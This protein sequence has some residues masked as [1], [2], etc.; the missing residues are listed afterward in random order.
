LNGKILVAAVLSVSTASAATVGVLYTRVVSPRHVEARGASGEAPTVAVT[1]AVVLSAQEGFFEG[2]AESGDAPVCPS[3]T[4]QTGCVMISPASS[5]RLDILGYTVTIPPVWLGGDSED[6]LAQQSPVPWLE[7]GDPFSESWGVGG[8][9]REVAPAPDGGNSATNSGFEIQS[10]S[11]DRFA[12]TSANVWAA[13]R[14]RDWLFSPYAFRQIAF[15][16][17]LSQPNVSRLPIGPSTLTVPLVP[18]G[19]RFGGDAPEPSTWLMT[20]AGLT[21]LGVFKRRRSGSAL[22]PAARYVA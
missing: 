18:V 22:R 14:G 6:V 3:Q 10:L 13:F 7:D 12:S 5:I 20:I 1:S 16:P 11:G 2:L 4:A 19:P 15:A 9:R 8:R 17:S 21:A